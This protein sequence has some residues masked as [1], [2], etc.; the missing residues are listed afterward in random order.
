MKLEPHNLR[1]HT[2]SARQVV[3]APCLFPAAVACLRVANKKL[4]PHSFRCH[5]S[6]L[7]SCMARWPLKSWPLSGNDTIK[8]ARLLCQEL[9]WWKDNEG[10]Q[11][12]YWALWPHIFCWLPCFAVSINCFAIGWY[13]LLLSKEEFTCN[14]GSCCNASFRCDGKP[15]C[16]DESDEQNCGSTSSKYP[17]G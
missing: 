6:Q 7:G 4:G 8:T 11:Q 12:P 9:I 13:L 1:S 15:D 5:A 17:Y 3:L 14:D 16:T 2:W 10:W